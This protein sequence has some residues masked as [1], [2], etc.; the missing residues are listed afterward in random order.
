MKLDR[1]GQFQMDE[2][3]KG[4]YG[5]RQ[6][7]VERIANNLKNTA[8]IDRQINKSSSSSATDSLQYKAKCNKN[9][10][11]SFTG[12]LVALLKEINDQMFS[13]SAH[14]NHSA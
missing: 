13:N 8:K 4:C 3:I 10:R 1:K 11:L 7:S 14:I 9:S 6:T 5:P 12:G 2:A